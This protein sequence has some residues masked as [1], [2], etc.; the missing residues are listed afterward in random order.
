V[1]REI[2]QDTRVRGRLR[3]FCPAHLKSKNQ[4]AAR[5]TS[6]LALTAAAILA[7]SITVAPQAPPLVIISVNVVDVVEG[8]I[9]V[10]SDQQRY[11]LPRRKRSF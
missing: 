2:H 7:S 6:F 4:M 5:A 11:P 8:R 10:L 1:I 9:R 3:W